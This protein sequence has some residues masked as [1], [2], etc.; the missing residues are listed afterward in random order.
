IQVQFYEPSL[1]E[2][3]ASLIRPDTKVVYVESPGSATFEIQDIPAIARCAHAVGA[4][5]LLDNTWATPLFFKLFEHGVD[6]S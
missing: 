3:I 6:V 4:Y 5:V 1:G 2:G